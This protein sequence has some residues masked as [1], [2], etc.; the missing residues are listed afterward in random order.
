MRSREI[1]GIE[2]VWRRFFRLSV[3]CKKLWAMTR[4][5]T[6]FISPSSV[7]ARRKML[8]TGWMNLTEPGTEPY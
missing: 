2:G 8:W 6:M 4:M 5:R 7:M 3:V 1:R